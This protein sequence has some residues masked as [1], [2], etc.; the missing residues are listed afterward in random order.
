[1]IE[2]VNHMF[3]SGQTITGA[4]K[5]VNGHDLTAAQ[6]KDLNMQFNFLN[7][8]IVPRVGHCM[9]IPLLDTRAYE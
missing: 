6:L 2:S 1:M 7:G 9:M 3:G 4:I 5:L 8:N